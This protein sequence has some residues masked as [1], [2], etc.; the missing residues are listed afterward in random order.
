MT[1]DPR[2]RKGDWAVNSELLQEEIESIWAVRVHISST[3]HTIAFKKNLWVVEA[4]AVLTPP[5]DGF[6][7]KV[8]T[9]VPVDRQYVT[10]YD[11]AEYMSLFQLYLALDAIDAPLRTRTP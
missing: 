3:H 2:K 5:A 11:R 7:H 1:T 9:L 8:V 10:P 4:C 6:P